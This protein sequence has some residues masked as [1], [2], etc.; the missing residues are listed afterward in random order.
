[1][2]SPSRPQVAGL[3]L[4]R[5]A[6]VVEFIK[7]LIEHCELRIRK[8]ATG[9]HVCAKGPIALAALLGLVIFLFYHH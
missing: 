8:D 9:W 5:G 3:G 2:R 6:R 7:S 4:N 1:M